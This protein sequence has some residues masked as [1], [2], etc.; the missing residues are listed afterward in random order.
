MGLLN[1]PATFL[2]PSDTFLKVFVHLNA[3]AVIGG[4]LLSLP[5]Y[6]LVLDVSV[7]SFSRICEPADPRRFPA[8]HP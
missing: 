2:V 7:Q 5:L 3:L 6:R 4:T 8:I 1:Q